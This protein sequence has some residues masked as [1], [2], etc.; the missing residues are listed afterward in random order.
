MSLSIGIDFDGTMTRGNGS[1]PILP[2]VAPVLA[3][4]KLAGHHLV[5][6]SARCTP[7]DPAPPLEDEAARFYATGEVPPRVT[8]Q[9]ARFDDMRAAL[10]LA[11][12]WELFDEIWQ[13]PGK[14]HCDIFV[15]DR[16]EE[17][18]WPLI[19]REFGGLP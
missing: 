11:G 1:S 7:A 6:H 4:L 9:W 8:D 19:G 10:K 5:L 3:A 13:A 18:N 15:D 2:E 12:L 17:P 16:L 14:P